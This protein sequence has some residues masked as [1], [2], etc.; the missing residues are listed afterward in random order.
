MVLPFALSIHTFINNVGA[1]VGFASIIGL[2]LLVLLNF[3][4]ARE[5]SS[6]RNRLEEAGERIAMLE[7]RL[8]QALRGA[9]PGVPD[10]PTVTPAPLGA[11]RAAGS[12]AA[13]S[14]GVAPAVAVARSAP[15][16]PMGVGAPAL[17]S[18]TR[19][20]TTGVT[21][22]PAATTTR[23]PI[24][25]PA[26]IA[27]PAAAG[28]LAAS[29][30]AG[31]A[32]VAGGSSSANEESAPDD[33]LLVAPVT[34]AAR[35]NGHER[36]AVVAPVAARN[37]AATAPPPSPPP[38][39]QIRQDAPGAARRP[40]APLRPPPPPRR[41]L[42]RRF[43]PGL[44]GI[45]IVAVVVAVLLEVTNSGG[46]QPVAHHAP[47]HKRPA[48]HFIA[49]HVTVAVLNG[50]AVTHL[51]KDVSN[52]LSRAGYKQGTVA[53]A[54]V[55]THTGTIVAYLRGQRAAAVHVAKALDVSQ[56]SL[57][58]ADHDAIGM[59]SASAAGGSGSCSADVIVTVGTDLSSIASA[60]GSG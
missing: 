40:M 38:R 17:A 29:G 4:Q 36:T 33:T 28:T 2:A 57:E 11:V 19:L 50:T 34:A 22:A 43:L 45:L 26:V 55:Q 46:G 21:P 5:T 37:A 35:G 60:A 12:A 48:P 9:R 59:C 27:A 13:R 20:V 1:Y 47:R 18:A 6:L 58:P 44:L 51:A 25:V 3:A 10:P 42:I 8:T 31:P 56:R 30:A 16:A 7:N 24:A 41:S 54:A 23:A 53:N 15:G 49:S 32:S 39:V 52:K 14:P